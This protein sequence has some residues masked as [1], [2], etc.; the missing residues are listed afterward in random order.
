[1]IPFILYASF[2]TGALVWGGNYG[3]LSLDQM[4]NL[5]VIQTN[6]YQYTVGAIVLACVAAIIAGLLTYVLLKSRQKK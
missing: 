4:G 6:I 2:W 3:D 1:M 5:D